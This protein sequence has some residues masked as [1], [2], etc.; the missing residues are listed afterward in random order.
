M[1]SNAPGQLFGYT[2]Q[3]PRALFHLLNAN[4]GD[5]ISVEV[6]GDVG[7]ENPSGDA[8]SEEDKASIVGNPVTDRSK[9]LWKTFYNWLI[10]IEGGKLVLQ[11]TRFIL[12]NNKAGQTG[13]ADALHSANT[14]EDAKAVITSITQELS[15]IKEDHEIWKYFD[16]VMNEHVEKF[17]ELIVRFDYET[18]SQTGAPEIVQAL[19]SKFIPENQIASIKDE[20]LGWLTQEVM[21][22]ISNKQPARIKWEVFHKKVMVVFS[23][24]RTKDLIDFASKSPP[25]ST[26]IEGHIEAKRTYVRQLEVIEMA[27]GDIVEAVTNYLRANVN[28]TQWIE[29]G[30]IDS[31]M[32]RDMEKQLEEFW[33]N[34]K[35]DIEITQ[36]HTEPS[37]RGKVLLSRCANK[38]HTLRGN[39]P[40]ASTIS[41][42]YHLLADEPTLGWHPQWETMFKNTGGI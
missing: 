30:I 35:T 31:T 12:Y 2:L 27:Q 25:S 29:A 1:N 17:K 40:P 10:D 38:T 19:K 23:R 32:A 20:L 26:D 8:T 14:P 33:K 9:N 22:H 3:I 7:V 16:Y 6:I 15:D 36:Q 13:I 28:R 11:K 41:G 18:G 24:Y 34:T 42:T 21:T 39:T 5:V 4:E 37:D